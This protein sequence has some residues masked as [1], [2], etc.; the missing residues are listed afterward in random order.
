MVGSSPEIWTAV[1][2]LVDRGE[3][4]DDLRR[5]RMHLLAGRR[6]RAIGR[7]IP[8]ELTLDER[9]SV[10]AA[11]TAP[12]LLQRV[13]DAYDGPLVVLKGPEVA[14]RY[15]DV[16]LRA[17]SDLDLLAANPREAHRALVAAGFVP[18]GNPRLYESIHHLQPLAIRGLPLPIELHSVPKWPKGFT[19]PRTEELFE[20]AVPSA[21]AVN[22][23]DTLP[24]LQHALVL[25][26]HSW[27]HDP[28]RRAGELVD[29][30]AMSDGLDAAELRSLA[31]RWGFERIW[32]T[33]A[34]AAGAL[35]EGGPTPWPLRTWARHLPAVRGRTVLESHLE[36][37]LSSFWAVPAWRALGEAGGVIVRE[38]RPARGET[39]AAKLSRTRLAMRNA[40][41]PRSSHVE[42]LERAGI[43]AP[44]FFELEHADADGGHDD[45]LGE[46]RFPREAHG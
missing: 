31:A 27:A 9:R 8:V 4:L 30:A 28:L 5:H 40:L 6:W 42:Q 7:A 41:V 1:D 17:Y 39:V 45:E 12:V 33:T 32:A 44:L 2:R 20:A 11:L 29:V 21:L 43:R 24:R 18:V 19:P 25:A 16:A 13:R 22:G 14:A 36:R 10:I 35:V 34:A 23:I 46:G 3:S 15:P 37:W 38:L 26:A